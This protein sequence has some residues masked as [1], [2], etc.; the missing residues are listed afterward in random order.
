MIE[1]YELKNF[2]GG[3]FIGSF[4]PSLYKTKQFEISVK[5]HPEGEIWDA[6]YH[7]ISTEYNCVIEGS[8]KI[9][10]EIFSK[11]DIFVVP[12]NKVV[13]PNFLKNC[14]IVCIKIPGEPNDKYLASI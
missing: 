3:W 6:H 9:D 13:N 1:K 10:D 5:F 14:T 12:P 8:V 7:K 11:G 2:I 4:E